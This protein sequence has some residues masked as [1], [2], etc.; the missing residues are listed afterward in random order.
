MNDTIA[1]IAT[2]YGEGAIAVVRMSGD[3]AIQIISQSFRSLSAN[4]KNITDAPSHTA[5]YGILSDANGKMIDEVLVTIFKAPH[6]YTGENSVEIGCHGGMK[7]T[8]RVLEHILCI[9]ARMAE[10]GEFTRRAFL[11]GKMDLIKAEAVAD[12]IHAQSEKAVR[13]ATEQLAGGLSKIFNKI[14]SLLIDSL[15]HVE[16]YIDFPDEDITPDVTDGL[17]KKMES[18]CKIA[19]KALDTYHEGE[20][21]RHGVRVAIAGLPNAGKSSLLNYLLKKDKAI[22]SAIPG[23][24][25]DSIEAEASIN[26]FPFIFID[27]AGLRDSADTIEA[28]GIRRSRDW[29]E[30]SDITLLLA[31]GSETNS[32]INEKFLSQFSNL[33]QLILVI[34]KSDLPQKWVIPS[35]LQNIKTVRT[36]CISGEGLDDLKSALIEAIS[37]N[38]TSWFG[39]NVTINAR[40][41]QKLLLC[42]EALKNAK[43]LLITQ[44]TPVEFI[45]QELTIATNAVGEILGKN[46]TEDLL[47]SIFS[48]FCIGK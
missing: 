24:T 40:H 30:K 43:S 9:G 17:L 41:R 4:S 10:P 31:D 45:A 14:H 25:R 48:H 6:S 5:H 47:D 20:I 29:I 13:A 19:Q 3:D 44:G 32:A 46:T 42:C 21:L 37:A 33:S 16:A 28:E 22:V 35:E 18:A 11:N 7:I 1:A 23:T 15:A 26:G 38:Q 2:P 34:N 12:L 39:A 27:T 8:Q 36:S